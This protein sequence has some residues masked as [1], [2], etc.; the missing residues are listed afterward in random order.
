[1]LYR[2]YRNLLV[3][4]SSCLRRHPRQHWYRWCKPSSSITHGEKV[5][6]ATA[7]S[8]G[9]GSTSNFSTVS[10]RT[11]VGHGMCHTNR[12]RITIVIPFTRST[13]STRAIGG[14]GAC[15]QGFGRQRSRSRYVPHKP[16]SHHH[17]HPIH[18][19]HNQYKSH[20]RWW[21]LRSRFDRQ[22]SR[23]QCAPH[24]PWSHHHRHPIHQK[25]NQ[26]KSHRRWWCLRSR[27][28]RQRS[29]L[30]HPHH[31]RIPSGTISTA[32]GGGVKASASSPSSS[33]SAAQSVQEPSA[34]VVPAV[35][36][37]PSAQSV[38]V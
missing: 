17:R 22:R 24:K 27:F 31:H 1:M 25:R 9:S 10:D 8:I 12:G 4:S 38:T 33:H 5:C 3:T 18:Q 35:K 7:I 2:K 15:G 20:R 11:A 32:I 36:V 34:V 13:I 28:D 6:I 19:K 29:R 14:G 21:C 23:S 16:W 30:K 26:Y 37:W